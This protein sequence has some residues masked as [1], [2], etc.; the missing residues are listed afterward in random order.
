MF[1]TSCFNLSFCSISTGVLRGIFLPNVL[2]QSSVNY[3]PEN[4]LSLKF[5]KKKNLGNI[6]KVEQTEECICFQSHREV[7]IMLQRGQRHFWG[8]KADPKGSAWSP[9]K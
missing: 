2:Q 1:Y 6:K 9:T 5:K 8:T 3:L 7:K 4:N